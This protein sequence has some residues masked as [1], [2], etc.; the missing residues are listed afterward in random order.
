MNK[1]LFGTTTQGQ[2]ASIYTIS[3]GEISAEILDF[4]ATLYGFKRPDKNGSLVDVIMA[5]ATLAQFEDGGRYFD[6]VCGRY[7]NRISDAKFELNGKVYELVQNNGK[8]HL[9]G[10]TVGFSRRLWS[11][12]EH[13]ES[14]ITLTYFSPDGEDGY[15]GD[16]ETSLT[17]TVKADGSLELYY[18]AKA[19]GDTIVNLTNHAFFNVAGHDHGTIND[20]QLRIDAQQFIPSDD[21]GIPQEHFADVAGTPYDF[22]ALKAVGQDIGSDHEQLRFGGGYDQYFVIDGKP[23]GELY[24]LA[25]K[26]C[27]QLYSEKTGI[28]MTVITSEPGLQLYTANGIGDDAGKDGAVYAWRGGLCLEAANFPNAVN[29]PD[30]PNAI[31]RAGETYRQATCYRFEVK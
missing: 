22:R 17:Y 16:L 20:L 26:E 31:L 15:P 5:P 29:R 1:R 7:A 23:A 24:G 30:Y 21:G 2:E 19:G 6:V 12:K 4:G 13:T 25:V 3:A 18:E 14:S 8:N 11:V 9:H 10:G 28:A 27:A